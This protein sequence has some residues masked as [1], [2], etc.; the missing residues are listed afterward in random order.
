[1]TIL[2]LLGVTLGVSGTPAIA[3]PLDALSSHSLTDNTL[4]AIANGLNDEL[5]QTT[6]VS[7]LS[8]VQPTDWAYT[9]LRSLVERYGAIAGYPDGTFRGNRALTRYEFAAGLTAVLDRINEQLND[10]SGLMLQREDLEIIQR[11]QAEFA[12]ELAT[13]RGRVDALEARTAELESHQFST[14]TRLNGYTI[15][16]V[17]AGTQAGVDDP[18]IAF[19]SSVGLYLSTS[20]N[21][22]DVLI[23]HIVMGNDSFNDAVGFLL[24]DSGAFR[25][26]LIEAGNEITDRALRQRGLSLD[27]FPNLRLS[28]QD[29]IED[30]RDTLAGNLQRLARD[31]EASTSEA[32]A[33]FNRV[34]TAVETAQGINGF[35]QINSALEYYASENLLG[36]SQL[37]YTFSPS[38]NISVSLFAQDYASSYV[39]FNRY[40]NSSLRDFSTYGF[41]NNQLL[42]GNDPGGAGAAVS[43]NPDAGALTLRAVYRADAAAIATRPSNVGNQGGLFGD[44]YLG[45]VEVSYEPSSQ[46]GISL[47]YSG[48]AQGDNEYNVLGANL[49]LGLGETVGLFGRFGYAYNFPG[50]IRPSSWSAGVTIADL[51]APGALTGIGVAQPLIFQE[52]VIN[53]FNRTQ[54]SFEA[55]YQL[56]LTDQI[57]IIPVVQVI[58]NPGNRDESTIWTGT[59]KTVFLF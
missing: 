40:A 1:M 17:N 4:P 19:T 35:L 24:G 11:L 28:N 30:I 56:P 9:A 37:S 31:A 12:G 49:Q 16:T 53:F 3:T 42:L 5:N 55:F 8:D 48:G 47:Q 22:N 21:G 43:W 57:S 29:S 26:N 33:V 46:F 10:S 44:P 45:I 51:F 14:T 54:T 50:D 34:T 39:D 25:N 41:I 36:L 6:A 58:T 20:F 7:Q 18:N 27:N 52:D 38:S 15:F 13:V 2:G 59:I 32:Q 23:T